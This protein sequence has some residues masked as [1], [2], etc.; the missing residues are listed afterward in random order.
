MILD[1]VKRQLARD[2]NDIILDSSLLVVL[3]SFWK[4]KKGSLGRGAHGRRG[5]GKFMFI[6]ALVTQREQF[7]STMREGHSANQN[8]LRIRRDKPLL[9]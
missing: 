1:C 5:R 6:S 8:N 4:R 7:R 2:S 9:I 3:G